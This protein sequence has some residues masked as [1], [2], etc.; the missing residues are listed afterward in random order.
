MMKILKLIILII[1]YKIKNFL[2]I[3]SNKNYNIEK[4]NKI[5]LHS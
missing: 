5:L 2:I 1:E 3:E 4:I